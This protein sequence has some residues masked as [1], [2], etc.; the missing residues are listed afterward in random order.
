MKKS[1]FTGRM[2][3][4]CALLG[5]L[6]TIIMIYTVNRL[7]PFMMD[8][9]WYGTLLYDESVQIATMGDI[10]KAQIWH[11]N[12]WGGRSMAHALLQVILMQGE[13]FADVLNT[14]VT[15]VLS[16][17]ILPGFFTDNYDEPIWDG[18]V[19]LKDMVVYRR[20]LREDM[21]D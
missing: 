14:L 12:N 9:L 2:C 17:I 21:N 1:R 3:V 5:F 19:L 6:F 7:V 8:D 11:Y 10:V 13:G 4:I 16:T 15:V 18:G 20:I